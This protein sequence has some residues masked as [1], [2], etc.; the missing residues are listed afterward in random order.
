MAWT[1]A[2][3]AIVAGVGILFVAGTATTITLK[4]IQEHRTYPWQVQQAL[5]SRDQVDQPPQVRILPSKFH[6]PDWATLNGKMIGTGV[7]AEDVVA[8]AYGYV[9]PARVVFSAQLPTGRYDYIAC[10]PGGEAANEQALQAVVKHK[11]GVAGKVAP[12]D[13]DMWLL[14][15]KFPNAPALKRNPR[16]GNGGNSI[17][18]IRG[19]FH[20]RNERM[21]DLADTLEFRAGVPITDA[22]GLT[23]Q[24]DFDLHCTDSDMKNHNW[25]AVNQALDQLGLELVPT[26]LPIEML[27]VEKAK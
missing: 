22:T 9:T 27:V 5:I 8:A 26:N 14:K 25:A 19:G 4:A 2:K 3:T 1:K 13:A 15:V 17:S 12:H 11:F 18:G 16:T 10:L 23:D 7:R 24:Y 6:T 20:G 21:F